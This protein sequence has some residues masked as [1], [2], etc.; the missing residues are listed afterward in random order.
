MEKDDL[1]FGFKLLVFL[2]IILSLFGCTA[3]REGRFKIVPSCT[4]DQIQTMEP[5]VIITP[6]GSIQQ[7]LSGCEDGIMLR[8]KYAFKS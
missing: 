5:D 7:D 1:P 2:I 3:Y 4:K 6:T 8:F